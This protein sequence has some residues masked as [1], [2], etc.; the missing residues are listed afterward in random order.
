MLRRLI[1]EDVEL[2]IR[3]ATDPARVYIDEA[4]LENAI[5]NLAINARDAMPEGGRLSIDISQAYVDASDLPSDSATAEGAAYVI[6]TVADTGHGM[7]DTV[8]QHIFEPFFTT[9]EPGRG[10]GLGLATTY[11]VVNQA[12][13]FVLVES[14]VGEGTTVKVCLPRANEPEE[15]PMEQPAIIQPSGGTETILVV[16]DDDSLRSFVC[17]ALAD[18][19]YRVLDA[20]E[21]I[22][23]M[24]LAAAYP[25]PIDL[26]LTDLVMPGMRGTIL[27]TG[28]LAHR[29]G[30][31][32]LCMSAYIEQV[33]RSEQQSVA[34][35]YIEKPFTPEELAA[36]VREAIDSPPPSMREVP[37]RRA[38]RVRVARQGPIDLA[39]Q[40]IRLGEPGESA[41][42]M[43]RR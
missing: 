33:L 27:A 25:G 38:G 17:D 4:Q 26:L 19:G 20:K 24:A 8:Q 7:D 14:G 30:L 29:P 21:G 40:S 28:L 42:P 15:P 18:Y 11:G 13:G 35:R 23:A 22:E 41:A 43:P 10:T 16:E 2:D 5:V 37:G 9:K 34:W 39:A 12:G 31:H 6:V 32:V 3:F 1:G 36:K